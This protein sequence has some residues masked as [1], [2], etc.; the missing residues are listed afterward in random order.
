MN[1]FKALLQKPLFWIV[2]F[3]LIRLIGI[4]NPPL[5]TG[6]NWRQVT[7]LMVSRN[8][9]EVDLNPFYPRVDDNRGESGIIGMEF[10][11][12]NYIY[13]VL[14]K[15]FG[16]Q[17]WYGRLI[18]LI[19]SSLGIF[20]FYKL[21]QREFN[22]RKALYAMLA[23]TCSIWFSYSRKMMPDVFSIS[24]MMPA[25]YYG[26][27]YFRQ[28]RNDYLMAY[29]LF[30]LL[31]GLSK[32]P[33]LI[34]GAVFIPFLL[35][36]AYTLKVKLKFL[37]SSG[38]L[39]TIVYLWYFWWCPHLSSEFGNWYNTG[40]SFVEGWNELVQ[41]SAAVFKNFYFH[42]FYSYLAF[43]LF[44]LGLFFALKAKKTK[45][46][47]GLGLPLALFLIY[48]IKSGFFFHHH[49]YY[50]IPI[51]P[52]L[53]LLIGYLL[54][55]KIPRKWAIVLIA[56][57]CLESMANQQHDFII[58]EKQSYKMKLESLAEQYIPPHSLV[59]INIPDNPQELYLSHRK[60]WLASQADIQEE[61]YLENLKAKSCDFLIVDFRNW[62][63]E[64]PKF[65]A[66][67]EGPDFGI[68]K[69]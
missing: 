26:I 34:Y 57:C 66:I 39:L 41:N 45:V 4:T 65:K 29:F 27:S 1:P 10:P 55:E 12:M 43:G 51:V 62:E 56:L 60:G 47:L 50:I 63:G 68:Y 15:L 58:K 3:L 64:N 25:L 52:A 9:L 8:F 22:Q 54:D 2:F 48:M 19:S 14:A 20:F 23:L 33:A 36:K 31:A 38:F 13:F 30:G 40:Q 69:L 17:H 61:E 32:I 46:L 21:I 35:G 49:N 11:L 16:Y 24:L 53:A 6:H 18:A 5:E 42:S 67:F 28:N 44:I 37:I 59:V 7:G